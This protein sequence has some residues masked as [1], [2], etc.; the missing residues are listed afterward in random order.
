MKLRTLLS[1]FNYSPHFLNFFFLNFPHTVCGLMLYILNQSKNHL[2]NQ[3]HSNCYF[4]LCAGT[5]DQDLL[6]RIYRPTVCPYLSFSFGENI[7]S[8]HLDHGL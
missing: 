4:K 3:N 7:Y 2:A 1:S 8:P 6:S 5:T